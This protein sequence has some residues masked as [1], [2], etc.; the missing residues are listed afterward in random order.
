M[1]PVN[2][3][4]GAEKTTEVQCLAVQR[5]EVECILREFQGLFERKGALKFCVVGLYFH[6][7]LQPVY[8]KG[9]GS[10]TT[11]YQKVEAT[12]EIWSEEGHIE[13]LGKGTKK[14][15]VLPTVVTANQDGTGKLALDSKII[16]K[17]IYQKHK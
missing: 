1:R 17:Q 15:Y 9:N 16:N 13:K 3:I 10:L 8:V 7:P 6:E 5:K 4:S 14:C 11:F 12:T 2:G